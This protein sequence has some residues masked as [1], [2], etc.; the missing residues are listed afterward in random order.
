MSEYELALAGSASVRPA[1][2][3]DLLRQWVGG[4]SSLQPIYVAPVADLRAL[5]TREVGPMQTFSVSAGN[6][7]AGNHWIYTFTPANASRPMFLRVCALECEMETATSLIGVR[8]GTATAK[9]ATNAVFPIGDAN[10]A[11]GGAWTVDEVT[12][13]NLPVTLFNLFPSESGEWLSHKAPYPEYVLEF[14]IA[15]GQVV[16]LVNRTQDD[17]FSLRMGYYSPPR[18]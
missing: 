13:A 17:A 3:K 5:S 10:A 2:W 16:E 18:T 11:L 12:N 8:V 14:D 9:A 7:G 4:R 1:G 6:P 15:A